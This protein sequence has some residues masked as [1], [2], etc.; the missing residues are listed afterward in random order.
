[1]FKT[2]DKNGLELLTLN[3]E[4]ADQ[5]GQIIWN[6]YKVICVQS[7]KGDKKSLSRK[8]LPLTLQTSLKQFNAMPFNVADLPS[9]AVMGD[10]CIE[11]CQQHPGRKYKSPN[12]RRIGGALLDSAYE[13]TGASVQPIIDRAKKFTM[14]IH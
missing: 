5:T 14:G 2:K 10:Q 12:R 11:F 7:K 3:G 6:Y 1:M 4:D 9:F 13:D 8:R